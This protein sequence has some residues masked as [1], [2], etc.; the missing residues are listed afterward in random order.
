MHAVFLS[1]AVTN[2]LT[3]LVCTFSVCGESGICA[4]FCWGRLG[5]ELAGEP[6]ARATGT[7]R[8]ITRQGQTDDSAAR[9]VRRIV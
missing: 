1:R 7:G 4:S 6:A 8:R 3:R 2:T 9:L 5:A